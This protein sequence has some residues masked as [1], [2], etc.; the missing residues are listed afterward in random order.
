MDMAGLR[1]LIYEGFGR[2]EKHKDEYTNT[3]AQFADAIANGENTAL[4]GDGTQN[5]DFTQVNDVARAYELASDHDLIG[6]YNVGTEEA[7][8]FNEMVE[9]INDA[10]GTDINPEYIEC[11]F[12][13]Y[14]CDSIWITPPY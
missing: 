10:L 4:F 3:V 11:A 1:F 2:N 6:V 5:R 7:Y 8:S 14:V 13:H 12:D 9:T